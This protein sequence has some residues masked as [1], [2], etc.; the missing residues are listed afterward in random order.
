MDSLIPLPIDRQHKH[1]KW[2][3]INDKSSIK[4]ECLVCGYE[5]EFNFK[6]EEFE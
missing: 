3:F 6:T 1:N 4:R 5:Q 2:G